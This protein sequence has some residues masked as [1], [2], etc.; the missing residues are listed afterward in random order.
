MKIE[1]NLEKSLQNQAERGL[2]FE[3]V[4]DLDWDKAFVAEDGREYGE[5]RFV[6]LASLDGRLHVVCYTWRGENLRVIS[7]RKANSK[8]GK[9]L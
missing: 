3:R 6:A 1:Y 8:R 9:S 7:F 2:G 4:K 5:E